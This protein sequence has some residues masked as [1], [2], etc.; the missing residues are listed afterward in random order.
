LVLWIICFVL[1]VVAS[2][3]RGYRFTG[4]YVAGANNAFSV[5]SNC[6][7]VQQTSLGGSLTHMWC[8]IKRKLD[9]RS[10]LLSD[11][12]V[13][14]RFMAVLDAGAHQDICGMVTPSPQCATFTPK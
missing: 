2:E 7:S 1:D 10:V 5:T 13:A 8:K 3:A 4:A 6:K 9:R 14:F 11:V 12:A